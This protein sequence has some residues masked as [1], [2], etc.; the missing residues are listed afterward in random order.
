MS[1]V[2]YEDSKKVALKSILILAVIT[3]I[4]VLIA[5]MGKGYIIDGLHFPH[6]IMAIAMISLSAYKAYLILY[7]F[8]HL[9]YEVPTFVKT[10]IIPAFLLV[11]LVIAL[12]VEGGYYFGAR[13][14]AKNPA[15]TEIQK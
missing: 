14:S 2:T 8:M 11:W 7:E 6:S 3:I 4:E 13:E 15:K 9:R 10:V 1:T 12:L 5:L